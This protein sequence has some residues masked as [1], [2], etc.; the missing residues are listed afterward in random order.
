M[1][2]KLIVSF[3]KQA[4]QRI[5]GAERSLTRAM[6]SFGNQQNRRYLLHA[7]RRQKINNT[8]FFFSAF[9]RFS[10]VFSSIVSSVDKSGS[11]PYLE[12]RRS[13]LLFRV[14]TIACLKL[15]RQCR[16]SF[17]VHKQLVQSYRQYALPSKK[18]KVFFEEEHF[19][20]RQ[21]VRVFLNPLKGRNL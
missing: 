2:N 21:K 7:P 19:F 6:H 20:L 17:T 18:R 13:L 9:S 11:W 14:A 4:K 8:S 16:K 10:S 15:S 1:E 3:C 5:Q 12:S